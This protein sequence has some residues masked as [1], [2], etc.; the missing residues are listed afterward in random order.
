MKFF[1]CTGFGD[2]I[3]FASLSLSIKIQGLC[4]GNGASP[5]GWAVVSI[6][7]IGAHKKKGHGAHFTCPITKLKSHITG[8]IYVDNTDL[9]H[10]H[11]DKDQGKDESFFFL[12]EAITNRGKLLLA[13]GG[14]LK[15]IKCFYHL[16]YHL[17]DLR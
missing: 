8:I 12:Q 6:C 11:M 15:P 5:A 10:F 9:L 7:I 17:G 4:Q 16:I 3:N 13:S 14:A 1:L 2:L